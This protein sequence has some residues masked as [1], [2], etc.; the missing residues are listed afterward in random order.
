MSDFLLTM[1][2]A[3]LYTEL[4]VDM[5]CEMLSGIDTAMLASCASEAEHQR[6]EASLDISAHMV[7]GKL[8]DTVE[9]GE[10]LTVVL[11]EAYHRLIETC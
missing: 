2:D 6:R 10:Y 4:L 5:L 8:I 7:V 11:E 9:E 3:H 1:T